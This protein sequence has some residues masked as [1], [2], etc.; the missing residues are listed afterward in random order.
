MRGKTE[1]PYE[2]KSSNLRLTPGEETFLSLAP[3]FSHALL[4]A[5]ARCDLETPISAF[6]KLKEEEPCFILES[7][8]RGERTGRYSILGFGG[9]KLARSVD[10]SFLLSSAGHEREIPGN[11]VE[12]LFQEVEGERVYGMSQE[13][14]FV[15]GAVGYFGY[16]VLPFLEKVELKGA[17]TSIPEMMFV[18]PRRILVFDHLRSTLTL[19]VMAEVPREKGEAVACYRKAEEEISAMLSRMNEPHSSM[20]TMPAAELPSDDFEGVESNLSR[21]EFEKAVRLAR[22]YVYQGEAF[23]IVLSQRFMM[24]EAPDA[25]L[26]YREL[27]SINPSPYMFY[28]DFPGVSLIGSSPEPMVCSRSGRAIIRP[29]AGT[30]PRGKGED[31]DERLASELLSD[32]KERAEHVMLVDLA[33]NDLGRV[34]RPASVELTGL[35]ELERYSHVMHMVSQVEGKLREGMGNFELFRS[36]FPA[37][38]VSGAPKV[39]ACQIIDELEHQRR[40]PYAGAVGYVSYSGD[41]D[42][43]ITIRTIVIEGGRAWVQAGAGVVADS[44]PEREWEESRNK[45]R[46]L[47]RAI[48][49]ARAGGG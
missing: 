40:G 13:L 48:Q 29:I 1:A 42:T 21:E 32:P 35:F 22:R 12:L 33:R 31:E 43:C 6:L 24:N 10:G 27:R 8:E 30:R 41:M 7:A 23:Q 38:T 5:E 4:T 16:D 45:A 3:K 14:P 39:R 2:G 18:F 19:G 36:A 34:C 26:C 44:V 28:L 11:P 9:V 49:A 46:A 15:G 25:L 37:G 47:L 20:G 17:P